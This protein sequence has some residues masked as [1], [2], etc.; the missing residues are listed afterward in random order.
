MLLNESTDGV[1]TNKASEQ[2]T[3]RERK[4][5]EQAFGRSEGHIILKIMKSWS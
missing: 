3:P 4:P 5:S 2:H 1:P